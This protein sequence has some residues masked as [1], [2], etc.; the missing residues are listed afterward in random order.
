VVGLVAPLVPAATTLH[1]VSS[2]PVYVTADFTDMFRILF[3]VIQDAVGIAGTAGTPRRIG[4]KL[5]QNNATRHRQG[6]R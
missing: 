2:G 1:L 4:L 5:E 6:R 3:K